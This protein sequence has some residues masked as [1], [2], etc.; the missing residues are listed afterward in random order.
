MWNWAGNPPSDGLQTSGRKS[1]GP[2][3]RRVV[4]YRSSAQRPEITVKKY[5]E[6]VQNTERNV[7]VWRWHHSSHSACQNASDDC[8]TSVKKSTI[9]VCKQTNKKKKSPPC[10]RNIEA[11]AHLDSGYISTRYGHMR[12]QNH[13]L[14]M[15]K[16]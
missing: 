10:F 15:T 14:A 9:K 16:T 3:D 2:T 13:S 5:L 12:D 4:L 1:P 11:K 6:D 7:Q 8:D